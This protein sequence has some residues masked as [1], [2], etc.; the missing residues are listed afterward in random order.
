M[1]AG[2]VVLLIAA[3]AAARDELAVEPLAPD[4]A[5]DAR[6]AE[7]IEKLREI[8]KPCS[9]ISDRSGGGVAF[10]ALATGQITATAFRELPSSRAPEPFRELVRLGPAAIPALLEHL[11]DKR[12]TKLSFHRKEDE[13]MGGMFEWPD[14]P[15]NSA[16]ERDLITRILGWKAVKE[17]YEGYPPDDMFENRI[18]DHAVTVGDCCF[19]ILGQIV[20]R[21]YEAVRYQPTLITVVSSPTREPKLAETLRAMWGKGDPRQVLARSL[22]DDLTCSV[23]TTDAAALRLLTYFPD[24]A[25][26]LVAR[27]IAGF[28]WYAPVRREAGE[29]LLRAALSTGH[30]LVRAEWLKLLDPDYPVQAQLAALRTVPED[31][32]K[33]AREKILRILGTSR[34]GEVLLAALRVLPD[35][36]SEG[37]QDRLERNLAAVET[38]DIV[39]TRRALAAMAILD[40]ERSV[41]I[42]RAHPERVGIAGYENVLSALEENPGS[43]LARSLLP[44]LLDSTLSLH[45][46]TR[47]CDA[48]ARLAMQA[49]PDLSFDP[50]APVEERDRQIATIRAALRE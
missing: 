33:D 15:A 27:R 47:V 26:P 41:P 25:A 6:I 43:R 23:W 18:R 3:T 50:K 4:P 34:D 49:R 44:S 30:V 39:A 35:V 40:N 2:V 38:R 8:D 11:D 36:K 1:R 45:R 32:G 21:S 24:E 28:R 22:R 19:A 12:E 48:A 14:L 7:L 31:P 16:A 13:G 46:D 29:E 5:R 20:N 10:D 17:G 42:F 37:L 9:G